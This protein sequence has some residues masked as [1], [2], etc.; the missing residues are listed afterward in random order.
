MTS[1]ES[2]CRV[3]DHETGLE[4]AAHGPRGAKH[5]LQPSY[6]LGGCQFSDEKDNGS[7]NCDCTLGKEDDKLGLDCEHTRRRY[8]K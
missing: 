7:V 2:L 1:S 6:Q 3:V 5:K 4:A 8:Y